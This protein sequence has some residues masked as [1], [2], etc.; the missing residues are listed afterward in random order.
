MA[1]DRDC[2]DRVCSLDY[3][4]VANCVTYVAK[5]P[6]LPCDF[7]CSF[8]NCETELHHFVACPVWSCTSKTTVSPSDM[9]TLSPLPTHT[10]CSSDVC[11][12]S[13]VFNVLFG[14]VILVGLGLFL[15]RRKRAL[16]RSAGIENPLFDED[17]RTAP[18]IRRSERMPLL[19]GSNHGRSNPEQ[20]SNRGPSIP[21]FLTNPVG[22]ILPPRNPAV[23]ET[24]F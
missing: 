18:I 16:A 8:E 19:G 4:Y 10:N 6:K 5:D 2:G 17:R 12:P 20:G 3:R 7:P 23:Q 1:A 22:S 15:I 14:I 13:I 21:N 9:S 11:V 24:A